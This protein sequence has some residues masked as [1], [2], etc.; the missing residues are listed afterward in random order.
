MVRW[1]IVNIGKEKKIMN[2]TFLKS[3]ILFKKK[4]C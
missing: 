3:I 4:M 2:V 1:L